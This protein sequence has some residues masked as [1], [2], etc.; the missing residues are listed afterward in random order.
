MLVLQ[1]E[2]GDRSN[3]P[4]VAVLITDGPSNKD[5]WQTVPNAESARNAGINIFVIGVGS[6]V[7]PVEM[8]GITG[9]RDRMSYVWSFDAMLKDSTMKM[10]YSK[11]CSTCPHHYAIDVQNE[12]VLE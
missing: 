4:N 10:M 11:I 12:K 1:R 6:E 5:S 7:D 8:K 9:S 3:A 2:R